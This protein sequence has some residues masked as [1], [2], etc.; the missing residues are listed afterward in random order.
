MEV[1]YTSIQTQLS[2]LIADVQELTALAATVS[3]N[4]Y[5]GLD[6]INL[7]IGNR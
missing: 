7:N 5:G 6:S 3:T 2:S 4:T 1:Y